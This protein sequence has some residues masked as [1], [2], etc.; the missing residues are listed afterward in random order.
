MAPTI[1]RATLIIAFTLCA[2]AI[3]SFGQRIEPIASPDELSAPA[4]SPQFVRE[5][6]RAT[7][8]NLFFAAPRLTQAQRHELGALS[9]EERASLAETSRA[10]KVGV[11][12]PLSIDARLD[13]APIT[14]SESIDAHGGLLE[15]RGSLAVWTTSVR[16]QGANGLRI[17]LPATPAP[18]GAAAFVYA[19][20]GE[21]HGPY[22][23][24]TIDPE[25][26]LWTN[27]VFSDELF[28]EFQ[29]PASETPAGVRIVID[30]VAHL[31][32]EMLGDT[33]EAKRS[34]MGFECIGDASCYGTST[35]PAITDVSRGVAQLTYVKGSSS[36]LCTGSLVNDKDDSSWI[37]YL[38]TANHCFATQAS[39]SSLEA[40]WRYQTTSCFGPV[41]SKSTLQRTLGSTLLATGTTSDFT[42]VRL[43]SLPSNGWLLGWDG[44]LESVAHGT[45]IHRLSHPLD[46][47]LIYSS[48]LMTDFPNGTCSGMPISTFIYSTRSV[49]TSGPGGSGSAAT[50]ANGQIVGQLTAICGDALD[51]PC[52]PA[53][54][55]I[56][57]GWFGTTY[58]FIK[59]WL[60]P[61]T[62]NLPCTATSNTFCTQSKRFEVKLS[63]KDPRSGKTDAG[64]VMTSSDFFGYFAFPVLTGNTTDPQVFVKV[65]DGRPINGK[66]WVFFAALSDVEFTLTVRDTQSGA[67]K[68]YYQAP[69][70]QT[71]KN[72]TSAF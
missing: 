33:A 30:A 57:D 29:I 47:P 26:G 54:N 44:R 43:S 27:T 36:Y 2:L 58:P 66:Y 35:Y 68:T 19:S 64:H 4:A 48:E 67:V 15:R 12:R 16:S 55:Y 13:L 14:S 52:G 39:A 18:A 10:T 69:Y 6:E 38:L 17:H 21:V 53:T 31:E 1:S 46:L 7:L 51:D 49:G 37:P 20:T 28:V 70:T 22:D 71:S 11:V 40:F 42:F 59:Q 24:A 45:R 32:H 60:V 34:A 25:H 65:L 63:A 23:L 56:V 41:P 62:S 5:P 61:T 9:Y 72:D 8:G 3:P 50:N